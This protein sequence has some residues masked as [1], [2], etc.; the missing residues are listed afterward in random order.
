MSKLSEALQ[1]KRRGE[2]ARVMGFG[3]RAAAKDR[4]LL[5]GVTGVSAKEAGAALKAGA[6][7]VAVNAR[8]AAAGVKA[9]DALDGDG[10]AGAQIAAL[11]AEGVKTLE[12]AGADFVIADP[13]GAAAGVVDSDLGLVLE[14]EEAWEEGRLRA[15]APLSLDAVLVRE[16]VERFTVARRISLARVAALCGAPLIVTVGAGASSADLGALRESGAG[17]VVPPAGTKAGKLAA[18]IEQLEAVPLRSPRKR[19]EGGFAIVP[20]AGGGG[21][22]EEFEDDGDED[23]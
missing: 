5:L 19:G 20:A 21:D 12:A 7:F 15:L 10:L 6:D 11:D 8:N 16:P 2:S 4:A 17:G 13:K 1:R 14:A 23:G 18:L 3:A 9:L 22:G